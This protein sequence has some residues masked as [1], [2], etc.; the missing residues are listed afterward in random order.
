V[1]ISA[2]S[3]DGGSFSGA[4]SKRGPPKSAVPRTV[5]V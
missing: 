3:T 4:S 1:N 5:G 2:I